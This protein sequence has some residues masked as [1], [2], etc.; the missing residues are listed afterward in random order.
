MIG[1]WL[2][3]KRLRRVAWGLVGWLAIVTLAITPVQS[4]PTVAGS[5]LVVATEP[6]FPPFEMQS[7]DGNGLQGFDIDVMTEIGKAVNLAVR[8][9]PLPFDGI[10]PALQSKT[11]DAAISGI[12][13]TAERAQ[14]VDFSSPYFKAGLAIAVTEKNQSIQGFD[15][16]TG[17]KIAVQIG[18]TGAME[19]KKVKGAKDSEFDSA[20]LALQ[21]LVNGKVDAVVN[22]APV[23]L[24]A[25]KEAGLKGVKVVGE[26][27]TEEF[28]GIALPKDSLNRQAVNYGLFKILESGVYRAIYQKWF[29]AEPP[30]LPMIAPAMEGTAGEGALAA[31][32]QHQQNFYWQLATNLPKGALL[33]VL[34]TALSVFFGMIGGAAIAFGF[35]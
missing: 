6:T 7:K 32:T 30:Q 21:E 10:I 27:L 4:Q 18:T 11:I 9:E 28:Y 2:R 23:T 3:W 25:L 12:T 35:G 5:S 17:K 8:F 16:L 26:L 33:T 34:L 1:R 31:T 24:Y 22:D 15:D 13:I 19:A 20:V 14:A 29:A